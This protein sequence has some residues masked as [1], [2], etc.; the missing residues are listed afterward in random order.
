MSETK[1][2]IK[3]SVSFIV[4]TL[5]C[6]LVLFNLNQMLNH[7]SEGGKVI[8]IGG[9]QR[10]LS[11]RTAL[12]TTEYLKSNDPTTH[13]Q[14]LQAIQQMQ[15]NLAFLMSEG[16][17]HPPK[18]LELSEALSALYLNSPHQIK[19]RTDKYLST[20][21]ALL[22]GDELAIAN[23]EQNIIYIQTEKDALLKS[24]E[25]AVSQYEEESQT[26]FSKLYQQQR[27]VILILIATVL[28]EGFFIFRPALLKY[29][30]LNQKLKTEAFHDPLTKLANRRGLFEFG[31]AQIS[32][33]QK[34]DKE[35]S[36]I[37]CDIDR[38]KTINDEYGHLAGDSVLIQFAD[39]LRQTVRHIDFV[40]RFGGEEFVIV[41]PDTN[42]SGASAVAEKIRRHLMKEEFTFNKQ[43]IRLT[44]S[45]G[46][47]QLSPDDTD[48][49]F[50][51]SCADKALFTSKSSGR[52]VVS[53]FKK[54]AE[55][56]S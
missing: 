44:A 49:L 14:A 42:A 35:C 45:F 43:S 55:S 16:V 54:S 7:Y 28:L 41:L 34:E 36:L 19:A 53:P 40:A 21:L 46:V 27:A 47:T 30:N 25:Y 48:F 17:K 22:N 51:I 33:V 11:Q 9:Q 4:V 29:Q 39:I 26:T 32:L 3:F 15:N 10:M 23:A 2:S 37:I 20:Q 38:F 13:Q 1:V 6:L 8:N 52:N 18:Y 50:A 31:D 56:I 24:L 5:L 12:L